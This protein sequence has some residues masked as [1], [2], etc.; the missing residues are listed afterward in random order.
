MEEMGGGMKAKSC[1]LSPLYLGGGFNM[2]FW[3]RTNSG[4]FYS[5][6]AMT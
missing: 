6:E 3:T 4:D 1:P 2:D 5:F